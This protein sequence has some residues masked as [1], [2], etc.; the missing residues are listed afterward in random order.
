MT[1]IRNA[2]LI[3]GI[4]AIDWLAPAFSFSQDILP[5]AVDLSESKY[6]PPVGNQG[7]IG[8]CDWFAAVY[9]QMTYLYNREYDRQAAA[10]NTFSPKFGYNILNNAGK[11]PYNI[12]LD[13]VYK[14]VEKHGCATIKEYPYDMAD[15]TGYRTWCTDPVIWQNALNYRIEGYKFFT[16][17]NASPNADQSF[18]TVTGYLHEIKR[19][20][21]DGEILVIQSDVFKPDCRFRLTNDDVLTSQD[22]EYSGQY[23]LVHGNNGPDHTMAVVGYNDAIW[24]DLNDDGMVQTEEKGALKIVDSF[25]KNNIEHR[26]DGFFWMAYETVPVSVFENRVNLIQIRH[27][28]KPTVI[29]RLILNTSERDQIKFR[30]GRADSGQCLSLNNDE[31]FTF[32]PYGMGYE[33]GTA[34]VSLISGGNFAYD[35]GRDPSDGSFVFDLSDLYRNDLSGDWYLQIMN[36]GSQPVI[37]KDFLITDLQKGKTCRAEKLPVLIRNEEK[38]LYIHLSN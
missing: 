29:C 36:S 1:L 35:G 6:F 4:L 33:P 24:T 8:S 16:L 26:N 38:F 31:A 20:L 19:L 23:I 27:S 25:G 13:D 34:G 12:R 10:E 15:G 9:Y 14:F 17:R 7:E 22:D 11:F 21:A 28:Y 32:D 3:T 5:S 37:I 2:L 18:D 30:F